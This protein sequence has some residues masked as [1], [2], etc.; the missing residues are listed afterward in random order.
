MSK[1]KFYCVQELQKGSCRQQRF[2]KWATPGG[3]EKTPTEKSE[4]LLANR[5]TGAMSFMT[6]HVSLLNPTM[7]LYIIKGEVF[8]IH[9]P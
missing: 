3:A 9:L 1:G 4:H 7:H 2:S 5:E 6:V 8:I